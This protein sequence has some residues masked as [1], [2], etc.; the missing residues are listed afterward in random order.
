MIVEIKEIIR[1]NK[2][3]YDTL[4]TLAKSPKTTKTDA[5]KIEACQRFIKGFITDLENLIPKTK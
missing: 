3:Q 1:K 5:L 2:I 4:D